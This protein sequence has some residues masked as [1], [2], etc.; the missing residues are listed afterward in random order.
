MR[1]IRLT[2][3]LAAIGLLATGV[4]VGQVI[5][6]SGGSTVVRTP[7]AEST[8]V[9]GAKGRTLGLSRVTIPAGGRIALH[10][11]QGTQV[12][13]V[14]KGVLTYTV[15]EGGVTVMTG[16]AD[17][18]SVVRRIAAGGTGRIAAGQWIVEQ[19]STIHQAA[20]KGKSPVVIYLST[21]LRTGAP[22]STPNS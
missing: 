1:R 16:P 15:K 14:Q 18:A 5:A 12:A 7:L 4:A 10:H 22:P 3:I 11:H 20:N 21:L 13:F 19:P 9:K 17:D 2:M 6:Q 8:K